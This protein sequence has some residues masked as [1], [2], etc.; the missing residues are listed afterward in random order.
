MLAHDEM[1]TINNHLVSVVSA[2]VRNCILQEVRNAGSETN[3][4]FLLESGMALENRN[5]PPESGNVDTCLISRCARGLITRFQIWVHHLITLPWF[6]TVQRLTTLL[7]VQYL[8]HR[9]WMRS[10]SN[11]H[12]WYS[13]TLL[14]CSVQH[15]RHQT[16]IVKKLCFYVVQYSV[17]RTVQ[18]KA[19]HTLPSTGRPVHSDTNSASPG[20]ILAMQQLRSRTIHSH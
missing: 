13:L 19:L 17:L 6:N 12:G 9:L 20:S 11:D 5:F 4:T 18:T 15:P 3:G 1:H 10:T 2:R 14:E 16:V 7:L 8:G